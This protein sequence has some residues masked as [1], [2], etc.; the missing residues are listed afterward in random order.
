MTVAAPTLRAARVPGTSAPKRF[1]LPRRWS[2]AQ[3]YLVASLVV[4]LAGVL[5]TGAW[6]GRQI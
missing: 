2:L 1:A 3:Q 4:V 5:V 6:I